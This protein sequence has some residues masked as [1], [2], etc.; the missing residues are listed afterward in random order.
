MKHIG[1]D[2]S[3]VLNEYFRIAG[4]KGLVKE[5]EKN[6]EENHEDVKELAEGDKDF[7]KDLVKELSEDNADKEEKEDEQDAEDPMAQ[8][9][10]MFEN[11]DLTGKPSGVKELSK[12]ITQG[13]AAKGLQFRGPAPT[14]PQQG[15]GQSKDIG[16]IQTTPTGTAPKSPKPDYPVQVPQKQS[17]L[18]VDFPKEAEGKVYDVSGETG[19]QLID[20]AHPGGGTKTELTHSK[21]EENLVETV[22][23]QQEKDI[24]VARSVPKGTYAALLQLREKLEK[25]GY[26]DKLATLD[27]A[28]KKVAS[29]EEV[30]TH[31]LVALANELDKRGYVDAANRVDAILAI[32][33]PFAALPSAIMAVPGALFG[34]GGGFAAG[35][36]A[37]NAIGLAALPWLGA[38]GAVAGAGIAAYFIGK[39]LFYMKGTLDNLIGRFED[40]DPNE[41]AVPVVNQWIAKLK[42]LKSKLVIPQASTDAATQKKIV[43]QRINDTQEVAQTLQTLQK[44]WATDI[45]PNLN[46]WGFDPDQAENVLNNTVA[47]FTQMAAQLASKGTQVGEAVQTQKKLEEKAKE[48]SGAAKE[49][50]KST[51]FNDY[52][53]ARRFSVRYNRILRDLDEE[54]R[55]TIRWDNEADATKTVTPALRKDLVKALRRLKD[56]GGWD[57][58]EAEMDEKRAGTAGKA[59]ETEG[60]IKGDKS[61]DDVKLYQNKVSSLLKKIVPLAWRGLKPWTG[62]NTTAMSMEDSKLMQ[63]ELRQ[64]A[65]SIV[66]ELQPYG[67]GVEIEDSPEI[68]RGYLEM[69]KEKMQKQYGTPETNRG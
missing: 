28:I 65:V 4:E 27:A 5:A 11:K 2:E 66:R 25:L 35:F 26:G 9:K 52:A 37:A 50:G 61:P 53:K 24:G 57:A 10:S 67:P 18:K 54:H 17:A 8:F 40:L 30:I 42:E 45:K 14:S 12:N 56:A 36:G 41:Q 3:T 46:D 58:F 48:Q 60:T 31:K 43:E 15:Q 69:M 55:N 64:M 44:Q 6:E 13:P 32:A 21:T 33:T 19:E 23:E 47:K 7:L 16:P 49:K 22:V 1:F 39:D 20:S 34:G 38:A 63:A 62:I 29:T 68:L 59:E 51:I